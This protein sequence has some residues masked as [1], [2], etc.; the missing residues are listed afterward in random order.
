MISMTSPGVTAQVLSAPG[1]CTPFPDCT[2]PFILS[3]N[4]SGTGEISV[5]GGPVTTLTGKLMADPT[6]AGGPAVLTYLLPEAVITGDAEFT[7]PGSP[8]RALSNVLRFTDNAG[9]LSG[10]ATGAGAR[11]IFY[12][13]VETSP[14]PNL[15]GDT[16]IPAIVG[17]PNVP[18]INFVIGGEFGTEAS[19]GWAYQPGGNIYDGVSDSV[20]EP[21]TWVMMLMGFAGLGLAG[22][23]K[24]KN[25]MALFGA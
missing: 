11:M 3:F 10:V 4:E 19:N 20:P 16:G 14:E 17:G 5:N 15:L 9:H 8:A 13:D 21:A 7:E 22:Y 2:D 23:R 24:A 25:R 1:A 18:G 12:S 6:V